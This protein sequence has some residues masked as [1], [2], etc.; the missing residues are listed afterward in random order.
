VLYTKNIIYIY[1]QKNRQKYGII[2][3]KGVILDFTPLLPNDNNGNI[4]SELLTMAEDLCIQSAQLI[5]S[6]APQVLYGMRELLR[7]VNSYYSNQ[8]ES[9]GTHPI[10]IDRATREEFSEDSK[11]K[12]LQQLSLVHIAV[13]KYV[14]QYFEEEDKNPFSKT[15]ILDVHHK[16]YSHPDMAPF[17]KIKDIQNQTTIKMIPGQLR[18]RDVRI[19]Q[20]IAP[21]YAELS[22]LFNK[23]E[24]LYRLPNYATQAKKVIYAIASHHRLMWIHPFLDGNGRTARLVLDG[25]FSSIDL[26]G[27][28]LWNISRGLSRRSED[29]KKYL[30]LADMERQGDLDGRGA[31]SNKAFKAYIKFMLEIALDQVDFMNQ[32]LKM[33]SL[34]DRIEKYIRLS[35]EGLLGDKPLPKYSELLF[36]ELLISGEVPRGKV[37]D[38]IHTKERTARTLITELSKMDYLESDT[39]KSP[40]RL[41]FNAHFA[42]Y[43]FPELIPQR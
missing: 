38:I 31:L 11:E 40:I 18:E 22:S 17:L 29:Y 16:L 15:F 30:A 34:H 26:K 5:G 39:P 8:I 21:D 42:S 6:H 36:K 12:Q 1:R 24:L 9:E 13:Q 27:Y 25:I 23:Y 2:Y 14:E 7:K 32:N 41:K 28:G 19:G 37:A 10:D 4:D 43:I 35:Q 33:N 20:H 3:S